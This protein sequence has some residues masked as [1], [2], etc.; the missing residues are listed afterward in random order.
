[1]DFDYWYIVLNSYHN[2]YQISRLHKKWI[3]K[4]PWGRSDWMKKARKDPHSVQAVVPSL[5]LTKAD[6]VSVRNHQTKL[7]LENMGFNNV[8]V[9]R[10]SIKY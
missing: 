9:R 8:E 4:Y 10:I 1:M 3:F 6:L 5:D 2:D 7:E